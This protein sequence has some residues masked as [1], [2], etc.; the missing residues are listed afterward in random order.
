MGSIEASELPM[1]AR[2]KDLVEKSQKISLSDS[3][4]RR[5]LLDV[6]QSIVHELETPMEA[7]YRMV[8]VQPV[9]YFT[10]RI[11]IELGLFDLMAKEESHPRSSAHLG[12]LLGVD[13]ILLGRLLKNMAANDFISETGPDAYDLTPASRSL[14]MASYRDGFPFS[15]DILLPGLIKMPQFLAESRYANPQNITDTPFQLGHSTTR[16]FFDYL[17]RHPEQIGQFNNYMGMYAQDRPRWLDP[18]NFPVREVL[19]EGASTEPDAALLVDVGGGKGHDLVTFKKTYGDLPGRLVLQDL[20]GAIQQA[21]SLPDGIESA[22]YDF[23]TPQPVKGARAYYFHSVL[24]GW[25]DVKCLEILK[26]ITAAMKPGYSKLL[27]NEIVIPNV[28]A[29]RMNTSLDLVMMS[30]VA[31]EERTHGNW[32]RLLNQAGLRIVKLWSFG[33]GTESV[34]EAELI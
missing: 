32:A 20:A 29:D 31:A 6:A 25:P 33:V 5:E 27:I 11:G 18:G 9:L 8:I 15:Q 24:H 34:I 17:A 10:V 21:G 1:E 3:T 23:F 2:V 4:S 28:G 13:P 26:N 19:G 16:T 7:I 12:G 22:V 30:V 14:T